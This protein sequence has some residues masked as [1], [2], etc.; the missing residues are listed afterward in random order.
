M[1]DSHTPAPTGS[2]AMAIEPAEV[3]SARMIATM[4]GIGIISGILLV[5]SYVGTLPTIEANRA[6]ALER[7][8]FEVVPG[9]T[10]K[11]TFTVEGEILRPVK[12]GEKP[13]VRY[14]AAYNDAGDLLGVAVEA[15][16]QGFADILKI[17]YG[18]SPG[19]QCVIGMKV[20]ESKE[21]PGLGDKIEK[22]P[23]FVSNF[24]ALDL[25]LGPDGDKPANPVVF[26][27]PGKKIN[28]WEIEGI[29][30]ATIS[31]KAVTNII[32]T[33]SMTTVAILEHN[34]QVLKD[35]N[36]SGQLDQQD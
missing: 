22:D 24:E 17:L 13:A 5:V 12:D 28:P 36:P 31:S 16:G 34:L 6:A 32:Y 18:Y 19:C 21:T 2:P 10:S 4:A 20:L 26:A 7:A 29:T 33:S 8:I 35:G 27:K 23:V 3:S 1:T 30:G 9:A 11:T 25:S 15:Q 14:Y